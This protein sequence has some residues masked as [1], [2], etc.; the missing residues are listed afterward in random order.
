VTQGDS[1]DCRRVEA[2]GHETKPPARFTEASLVKHLE[3]EGIGRPSTY[4]SIIDTIQNRGY[5]RKN[6]SQLVPTFTAFATNNLLEQ[7]FDKLVDIGFTATMEED[8]DSIADGSIEAGPYLRQFYLGQEGLESRIEAGLESIDARAV[9]ELAYPQWG[10]TVRVGR[11]GPYVETHK[12]GERITASLPE[13]LSP[14][15]ITPE[16]LSKLLEQGSQDDAIGSFP[17]T[18]EPIYLRQGPYG[19]YVQLGEGDDKKKPKR[20]SLPKGMALDEVTETIAIDL[21][22]LPRTLGEHPETGKPIKAAIGRFGPYVQHDKVFASLPKEDNV[23]SVGFERAIEL[24]RKKE[25]RNKPLRVLGK[26]PDTGEPIEV[27]EGRYGPYVKHEK[28]NAS[29]NGQ[30]VESITLAEALDLIKERERTT[31]KSSGK[32]KST[33]ASKKKTSKKAAAKKSPKKKPASPKATP[34]QLSVF[35]TELDTE[36]AKVI[37]HL[38]GLGTNKEDTATVADRLGLSEEDVKA[39]HKRG[40][41]KLRM[42]YGRARKAEQAQA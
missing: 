14:A 39:A 23:L 22:S 9:S 20:T 31:G 32:S 17:V 27:R 38:E 13:N 21:L 12:D 26:H 28:T 30:S 29:L 2:L 16:E 24:I 6:G 37:K 7:Q 34:E 41:F 19:P 15:D 36:D 10:Y 4:A 25:M 18:L 33:T 8:L 3:Q 40:M 42:A 11:Y 1:L 5:A 35:L